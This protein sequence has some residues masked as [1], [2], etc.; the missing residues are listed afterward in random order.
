[1]SIKDTHNGK[2]KQKRICAHLGWSN[3]GG[4]ILKMYR[5]CMSSYEIAEY[6][7]ANTPQWLTITPRSI[8]R[9]IARITIDNK[10]GNE[11]RGRKES[12]QNAIKRGRV[13]WAWKENKRKRK[14]LDPKLRF[15]VLERDGFC[16]R[17]CGNTAKESVLEVDHIVAVCNGGGNNINNLQTLCYECNKGKFLAKDVKK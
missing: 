11:V 4:E 12:F 9:L 13:Q 3:Y 17:L 14:I 10:G 5:N 8:S 16:C 15:M 1:M 7:N 2:L 6:I